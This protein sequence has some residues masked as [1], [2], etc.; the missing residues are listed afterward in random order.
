MAAGVEDQRDGEHPGGDDGPQQQHG[1]LPAQ[2]RVQSARLRE[3]SAP[4]RM[5]PPPDLDR[6]A[7]ASQR[8][9]ERAGFTREGACCVPGC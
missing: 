1:L 4:A 5:P 2:A 3:G 8:V 9:A 6:V 7:L